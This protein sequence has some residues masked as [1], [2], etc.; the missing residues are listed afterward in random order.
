MRKPAQLLRVKYYFS[1]EDLH[2]GHLA[3]IVQPRLPAAKF[4]VKSEIPP[5]SSLFPGLEIFLKTI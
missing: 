2:F 1:R 3:W 5:S 4:Y